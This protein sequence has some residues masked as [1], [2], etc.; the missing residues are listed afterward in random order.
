[1][2]TAED[3]RAQLN[4]AE[5]ELR[6]ANE[7]G[8]SLEVDRQEALKRQRLRRQLD[9]LTE[10]VRERK[11]EN[12]YLQCY[13][14]LVDRDEAGP[15][16]RGDDSARP[17]KTD[18]AHGKPCS[19][20][21]AENH[22]TCNQGVLTGE[23]V[24]KIE[25]L[26][27]IEH[28][29]MHCSENY[30]VYQDTFYVGEDGFDFAYHPKGGRINPA[31]DTDD[32]R[33]CG[34]LALR[35]VND[36]G[37]TFRYRIL[38]RGKDGEFCQWGPQGNSLDIADNRERMVFGPDVRT[39]GHRA[40]GV[41]GLSHEELLKSDWVQNDTLTVKFEL[42]VRP[43]HDG[44]SSDLPIKRPNL[45]VPPSSLISNFLSC[46][47]EGKLSDVTFT[48]RG[49]CIKA[50][51]FVL[52]ARSEVFERELQCGMRESISKE[53]PIVDCEP[54]IF[55]A[56]LR[57]L[58]SDDFSHIEAI[59][60]NSRPRISDTIESGSADSPTNEG[61][62]PK[63]RVLQDVLSVSHKYQ[64]SRLSLWCE[65]QLCEHVCQSEVCSL[66]RQAHLLDA[67]VLEDVCLKYIKTNMET[68]ASTQE[69]TEMSA[70]WPELLL[71]I[72]LMASGA[73]ANTTNSAVLAQQAS[74]RKR[75]RE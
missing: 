17:A 49:E 6:D 46:L 12:E 8:K 14:K 69:F 5:S 40:S 38:V 74:L 66:L 41:F 32:E 30:A 55:K 1:M 67:K 75:K 45:E 71:K 9:K 19:H 21:L 31:D 60:E 70:D 65:Q 3:I 7:V 47:D 25:G 26:S 57:F 28:A 39:D 58:Y 15:W 73:S 54:Y 50:H 35:C 2:A 44:G 34:S 72:S 23:F 48:V 10:A 43:C 59:V 62:M 33:Y 27:W 16:Q 37:S 22:V 63:I 11:S 20:T 56:F 51:F 36:S 64:V 61:P 13:R 68:L 29:L 42:Q 18:K 24:W 53:V 4:A 52:A